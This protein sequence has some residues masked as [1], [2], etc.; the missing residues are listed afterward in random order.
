LLLCLELLHVGCHRHLAGEVVTGS[1]VGD[2][3]R[4]GV[5]GCLVQYR[6]SQGIWQAPGRTE[7]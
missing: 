2:E 6:A 7:L 3:H 4:S 5:C 1:F